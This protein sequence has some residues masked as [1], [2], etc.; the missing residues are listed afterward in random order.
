MIKSRFMFI[1][2]TQKSDAD[3]SHPGGVIMN[4]GYAG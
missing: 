4:A 3:M 2:K 1:K